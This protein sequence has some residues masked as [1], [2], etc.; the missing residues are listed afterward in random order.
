MRKKRRLL[1]LQRRQKKRTIKQKKRKKRDE[2]NLDSSEDESC[3]QDDIDLG[4][5]VLVVK[6]K[7]NK[8][9]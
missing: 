6:Q 1:C 7:N 4:N 3:E 2:I 5:E 9:F 8:K